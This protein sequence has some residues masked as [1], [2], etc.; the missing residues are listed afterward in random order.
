MAAGFVAVPT[1]RS[2]A[3]TA[4]RRPVGFTMRT[5]TRKRALVAAAR[6]SA[7]GAVEM[8]HA[9]W[10]TVFDGAGAGALP[11]FVERD[12]TGSEGTVLVRCFVALTAVLADE[13]ELQ[14]GTLPQLLRAAIDDY[15]RQD[16]PVGIDAGLQS[17]YAAVRAALG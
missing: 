1:A 13:L 5:A 7:A 15:A 6:Q 10:A 2:S 8:D 14:V 4:E 16:G 17:M 12:V 11:W 9:A 3:T